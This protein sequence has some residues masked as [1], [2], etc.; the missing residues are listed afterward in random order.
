MGMS[1]DFETAVEEGSSLV[2]IGRRLFAPPTD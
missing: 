1:E 2:R